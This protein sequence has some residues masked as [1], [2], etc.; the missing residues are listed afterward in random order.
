MHQLASA[1]ASVVKSPDLQAKETAYL[2]IPAIKGTLNSYKRMTG[3][4]LTCTAVRPWYWIVLVVHMHVSCWWLV[5]LGADL[6]T[7]NE[8]PQLQKK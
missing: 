4:G 1:A 2:F 7:D 8:V 3:S 5:V 6:T